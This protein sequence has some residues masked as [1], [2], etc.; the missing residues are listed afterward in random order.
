M[1][2]TEQRD[3]LLEFYGNLSTEAL[4]RD[5]RHYTLEVERA[6]EKMDLMRLVLL[7]RGVANG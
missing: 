4:Q 1:F 3:T 5:I 2:T 6:K 7:K